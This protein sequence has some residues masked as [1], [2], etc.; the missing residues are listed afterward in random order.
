MSFFTMQIISIIQAIQIPFVAIICLLSYKVSSAT[1]ITGRFKDINFNLFKKSTFTWISLGAFSNFI[2]LSLHIFSS[3]NQDLTLAIRIFDWSTST[4]FFIAASVNFLT[5]KNQKANKRKNNFLL[6]LWGI[7]FL[8]MLSTLIININFWG[9]FGYIVYSYNFLSYLL[10]SFTL[11]FD[12]KI[13]LIKPN[14]IASFL[15]PIGFFIWAWLQWLQPIEEYFSLDQTKVS[16]IGFT[17]STFSKLL[18]LYGLSWQIIESVRIGLHRLSKSNTI[19]KELQRLNKEISLST[20]K[21]Q[22]IT[23]ITNHFVGSLLFSFDYCIFYD[24]DREEESIKC[25]A[26]QVAKKWDIDK[27]KIIDFTSIPLLSNDILAYSARTGSLIK[28]FNKNIYIGNEITSE[29]LPSIIDSSQFNKDGLIRYYIPLKHLQQNDVNCS[30]NSIALIEVGQISSKNIDN[31]ITSETEAILKIYLDSCYQVFNKQK[32]EELEDLLEGEL[33]KYETDTKDDYKQYLQ[34]VIS[35][36]CKKTN[37]TSGLAVLAPYGTLNTNIDSPIVFHNIGLREQKEYSN[38]FNTCH[39]DLRS[40]YN[41]KFLNEFLKIY[42]L[43]FYKLQSIPIKDGEMIGFICIYSDT[44]NFFSESV[45]F[46]LEK[47]S[48]TIGHIFNEKRFHSS[49]ADLAI[50]DNAIT[51]YELNIQP[52]I[53]SLIKYFNTSYISIWL[54]DSIGTEGIEYRQF[55]GSEAIKKCKTYGKKELSK[56]IVD[57]IPQFEVITLNT[58]SPTIENSSFWEFAKNNNLKAMVNIPLQIHVQKLGFINVY[59]QNEIKYLYAEDSKFM[60]LIAGKSITTLQIHNIVTAFKEISSSYIKNELQSTLSVIAEKAAWL[61]NADPVILYK[62]ENGKDIYSRDAIISSKQDKYL[63]LIETSFSSESEHLILAELI[64]SEKS[65]YFNNSLEFKAYLQRNP[66]LHKR[67]TLKIDFWNKGNIS[68]MAA[69]RLSNNVKEKGIALGIMFINFQYVVNFTDDI[70]KIIQTFADFASAA[71]ESSLIF[72]KNR[73]YLINNLKMSEPIIGEMIAAGTLHDA[74]KTFIGIR[75]KYL[76]I[77]NQLDGEIGSRKMDVWS[78][79]AELQKLKEP[80]NELY[81]EFRKL[82]LYY[83]PDESLQFKLVNLA[84]L[85]IKQLEAVELANKDKLIQ[86]N[87]TQI[88]KSIFV[89]CDEVLIGHSIMNIINNAFYAMKKRGLLEIKIFMDK[90][91]KVKLEIID[92]GKGINPK[93]Y[94]SIK[95]MYVSDKIDGSGLGLAI[96]NYYVELHGGKLNYESRNHKTKFTIILPLNQP[97]NE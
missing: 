26:L 40:D 81:K 60:Q 37:A 54:L 27:F 8:I 68:S 31:F 14:K 33:E 93:I 12:V 13:A 95:K 62:C 59:F 79:R 45:L 39:Y 65:Q 69:I 2:Y 32:F 48:T 4:F 34:H 72:E 28:F 86:I 7:I 21:S 29:F 46:T 83:K 42:S 66:D 3:L 91:S 73:R 56:I 87:T 16:I 75:D 1:E 53:N 89:E 64:I 67:N 97:T 78:M 85:T 82:K 88:D 84:S 74:H 50:H 49:V 92:N 9:Q 30:I 77:I 71:L 18:I 96:S 94:H 57:S 52:I 47:I 22:F 17:S 80:I 44:F 43:R 25:H 76:D 15:L 61:L 58:S 63:K 23:I 36:V 90:N 5:V 6:F 35:L 51:D 24:I 20:D 19:N 55:Y 11:F 10:L 38:F 70:K 41:N